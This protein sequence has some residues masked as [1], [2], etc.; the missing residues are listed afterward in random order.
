MNVSTPQQYNK[1]AKAFE[2][3]L[4]KVKSRGA[5]RKTELDTIVDAAN[6]LMMTTNGSSKGASAWWC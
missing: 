3:L 4:S 2:R 1:M 5:I 6:E